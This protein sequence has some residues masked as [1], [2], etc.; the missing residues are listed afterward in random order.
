MPPL[1]VPIVCQAPVAVDGDTIRCQGM[2]RVRLLAID[3]PE[4]PGHCRN[5]R[6][7]APGDPFKS[8]AALAGSLIGHIQ[9]SPTN[10]D[11]Y[12]RTVAVVYANGFNLSCKQLW[13]G[14]AR[15]WPR[16]DHQQRIWRECKLR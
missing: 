8:K 10:S 12:G 16:Y 15:Y 7:C 4:M 13:G 3:A 5:G 2:G 6:D 14:F 1:P 11:P 9:V